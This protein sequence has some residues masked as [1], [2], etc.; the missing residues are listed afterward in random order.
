MS[1]ICN[2][3]LWRHN[4]WWMEQCHN[5]DPKRGQP[6]K[7]LPD[8]KKEWFSEKQYTSFLQ[9]KRKRPTQVENLL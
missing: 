5:D 8:A 1:A 7:I 3:R 6:A 2:M 4:I 9:R